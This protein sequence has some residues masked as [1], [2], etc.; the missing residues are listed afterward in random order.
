MCKKLFGIYPSIP[1]KVQGTN[2]KKRVGLV[3]SNI[4]ALR[5]KGAE[6][7]GIKDVSNIVLEEDGS[8]VES[9]EYLRSLSPHTVLIFLQP[10]DEW[11]GCKF[12]NCLL[13][14]YLHY[15]NVCSW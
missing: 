15:A 11:Q 3:A 10:G 1:F 5:K 6:K 7:L 2:G 9:D 12:D 8:E 4:R 13:S 14:M